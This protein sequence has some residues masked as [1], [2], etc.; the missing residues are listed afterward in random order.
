MSRLLR[1]IA[2]LVLV[3]AGMVVVGSFLI[4]GF[5]VA[6]TPPGPMETAVALRMRNFSIPT[7]ARSAANPLAADNGAWRKAARQFADNCAM[8]HNANGDGGGMIGPHLYPRVPDM[9]QARTQQL[10]DG[11][12]FYL[13]QNGVKL[14]G[15][16]A[17]KGELSDED[18][19]RLVAFIRRLPT[20]TPEEL[21]E[22]QQ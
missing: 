13:I 4:T 6:T 14:T 1:V 21:D 5:F 18:I 7:A 2:I 9:R 16:P 17:W 3:L 20:L 8:C 10:T 15:M 12:L 11:Q 22:A 19:W